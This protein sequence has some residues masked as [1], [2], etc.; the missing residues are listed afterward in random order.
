VHNIRVLAIGYSRGS[1]SSKFKVNIL[2]FSNGH[3][4]PHK[5]SPIFSTRIGPLQAIKDDGQS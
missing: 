5:K 1:Q 4:S 2:R 3:F